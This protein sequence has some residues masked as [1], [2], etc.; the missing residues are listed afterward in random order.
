[1]RLNGVGW[2]LMIAA[3]CLGSTA[4]DEALTR[5]VGPTPN[6][7]PTFSSIQRDIFEATDAAGRA[8]CTGCHNAAGSRFNGID[9]T[10]SA[11]YA[12]LVGVASRFKPGAVRVVPGDP[13]GSYLV[14]KLEGQAAIV[15]FRMP[16]NG[17]PYLT[18]GQMLVIRRWIAIGA[19]NN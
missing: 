6:L 19:P 4:C 7:Q 5:L 8:A 15:G 1:M 13:D 16:R 3:S 17:P 18:S 14:Q 2:A 10:A 9:L 12:S 11:A